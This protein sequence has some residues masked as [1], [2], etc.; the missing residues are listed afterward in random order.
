MK[1]TVVMDSRLKAVNK[2]TTTNLKETGGHEQTPT[3]EKDKPY[4]CTFKWCSK[5]FS[6][7]WKLKRH[8]A[9]HSK[10]QSFDVW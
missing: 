8:Q 5:R 6:D 7:N 3:E 4:A 2:Q 10:E 9:V 1:E